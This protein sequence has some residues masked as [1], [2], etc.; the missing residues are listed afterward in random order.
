MLYDI[1]N[2][3]NSLIESSFGRFTPSSDILQSPL[4]LLFFLSLR[5]AEFVIHNNWSRTTEVQRLSGSSYLARVRVLKV[6]PCPSIQSAIDD[7]T[8]Y[9]VIRVYRK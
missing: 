8:I 3:E 9:T 6:I 5:L 4:D 7:V 2:C 1:I